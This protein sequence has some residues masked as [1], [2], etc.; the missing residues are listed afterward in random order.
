MKWKTQ[1]DHGHWPR[2]VDSWAECN[3]DP[4]SPQPSWRGG[5]CERTGP[6]LYRGSQRNEQ[7][8]FSQKKMTLWGTL[9]N[10]P[11]ATVPV[12]SPPCHLS[13][14]CAHL[15]SE[16]AETTG[17]TPGRVPSNQ[18][19]AHPHGSARTS[20]QRELRLQAPPGGGCPATGSVPT[21]RGVSA[22]HL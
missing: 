17:I 21:H 14:D 22:P 19:G 8:N 12:S 11:A 13:G 20:F 16:G 18:E 4:D 10:S 6:S 5:L 15:I 2:R 1:G 7:E 9:W 3:P